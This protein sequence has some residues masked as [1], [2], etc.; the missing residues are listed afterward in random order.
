MELQKVV[1]FNIN[2]ANVLESVSHGIVL[3]SDSPVTFEEWYNALPEINITPH[4]TGNNELILEDHEMGCLYFV[5]GWNQYHLEKP[6]EVLMDRVNNK[7]AVVVT[8]VDDEDT[9][10]EIMAEL[11]I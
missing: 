8:A 5:W 9:L 4:I 2:G 1:R 10:E 3:K 7:E 6:Y 11:E